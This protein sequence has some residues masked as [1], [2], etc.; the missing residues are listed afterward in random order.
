MNAKLEVFLNNEWKSFPIYNTLEYDER[1]DEQL[2]SGSV[3]I[4]ANIEE[5]FDDFSMIKIT[6]SD[7]ETVLPFYYYGFD[8]IERRGNGYYLHTIELAEPSRLLMGLPIDGRKVTQPITD[9]KK[10]LL[11]VTQEL[12]N[13]FKLQEYGKT[14]NKFRVVDINGDLSSTISPEFG[15]DLGTLLW[16]C[17]TDIGN[18][19]NAIPRLIGSDNG[20]FEI[21]FEKI[22]EITDFYEL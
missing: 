1:L 19:I 20:Y 6:L 14:Q 16:E 10:S 15:W 17:L 13:V 11:Q 21:V 9:D 12:L 8:K 5:A 18:V 2:D 4:T 22:N 3:Q 7:S